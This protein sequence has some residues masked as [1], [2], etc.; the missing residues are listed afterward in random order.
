MKSL[1]VQLWLKAGAAVNID[2][3]ITGYRDVY[4]KGSRDTDT[5]TMS[6]H[7]KT[8]TAGPWTRL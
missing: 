1:K 8:S 7:T 3:G 5:T 2:E 6:S 4:W